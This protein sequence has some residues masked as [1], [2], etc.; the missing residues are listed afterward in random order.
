MVS[1]RATFPN[2]RVLPPS[3]VRTDIVGDAVHAV[4]RRSTVTVGAELVIVRVAV[5]VPVVGPDRTLRDGLERSGR[6]R[7]DAD[8]GG[9]EAA[10]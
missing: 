7:P 6:E 9:G 10:P 8:R 3:A 2:A 4:A 1:W 5:G